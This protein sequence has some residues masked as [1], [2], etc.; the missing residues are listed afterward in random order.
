ML[1]IGAPLPNAGFGSINTDTRDMTRTDRIGC[2]SE[3]GIMHFPD[4][5]LEEFIKIDIEEPDQGTGI[6]CT[7]CHREIRGRIHQYNNQYFD[8]YCWNLRFILKMGDEEEQ[9]KDELRKYLANQKA[10]E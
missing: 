10:G 9:R 4:P 2:V 3:G 8:S 1:L 5:V 6:L 7:H